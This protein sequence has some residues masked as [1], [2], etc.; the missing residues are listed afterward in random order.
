MSRSDEARAMKMLTKINEYTRECLAIVVKRRLNPEDVL[1]AL[2][3]LFIECGVMEYIGSYN[4]SKFTANAVREWLS[5]VG[6]RHYLSNL[7]VLGKK[8]TV[9]V[10][11]VNFVTS[12]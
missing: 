6:E 12:F 9:K 4:G 7:E 3:D 2:F 10:L 8:V 1:A 5:N 11:M